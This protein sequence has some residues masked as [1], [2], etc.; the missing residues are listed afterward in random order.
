M[1][2][3][4]KIR[5][6]PPTLILLSC[7]LLNAMEP[8]EQKA[9][10]ELVEFIAKQLQN[11]ILE[12]PTITKE[13]QKQFVIE[14]FNELDHNQHGKEFITKFEKEFSDIIKKNENAIDCLQKANNTDDAKL[15]FKETVT[16]YSEAMQKLFYEKFVW[17]DKM[18]IQHISALKAS[19]R[20]NQ[21]ILDCF[22]NSETLSGALKCTQEKRLSPGY[23]GRIVTIL[24]VANNNILL[25]KSDKIFPEKCKLTKFT[26]LEHPSKNEGVFFDTTYSL[27]ES[28]SKINSSGEYTKTYTQINID[29]NKLFDLA[30]FIEKNSDKYHKEYLYFDRQNPSGVRSNEQKSRYKLKVTQLR[31]EDKYNYGVKGISMDLIDQHTGKVIANTTYYDNEY[32]KKICGKTYDG[33]F[34]AEYFVEH[35]FNN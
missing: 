15:C 4:N 3:V 6:L 23:D 25:E 9:N 30:G 26:I 29:E 31:D 28:Y 17:S 34:D 33:N 24:L 7:M 1:L 35:V 16:T 10:K 14:K 13:E 5:L 8:I 27:N 21:N 19:S 2:Y 11:T 18:K 32:R 22:E 20:I 12:N